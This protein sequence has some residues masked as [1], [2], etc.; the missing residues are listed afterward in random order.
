[1]LGI[2]VEQAN[3]SPLRWCQTHNL[4]PSDHE[5]VRLAGEYNFVRPHRALKF[6]GVVR[7]PAMQAGLTTRRLTL[8]ETFPPAMLIWLSQ[9]IKFGQS[10]VLVGVDDTRI[11]LAA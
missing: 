2:Y 8:R 1:M 5:M 7:T 3:G 10:T 6:G 4:R 11:L 9:K